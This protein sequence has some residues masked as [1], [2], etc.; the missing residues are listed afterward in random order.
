M[1]KTRFFAALTAAAM[2]LS[3][4]ILP[5]SAEETA[6]EIT[7]E[8]TKFSNTESGEG[9]AINEYQ[10]TRPMSVMFNVAEE[11]YYKF[12]FRASDGSYDWIHLM[13]SI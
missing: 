1:K 9:M 4:A 13:T 6:T 2:A 11:G 12:Q 10:D 7:I 8:G 3:L 5:A